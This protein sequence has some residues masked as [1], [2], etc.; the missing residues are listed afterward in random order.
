MPSCAFRAGYGAWL[1]ERRSGPGDNGSNNRAGARYNGLQD[2]CRDI[3][4]EL[5]QLSRATN[6]QMRDI[7]VTAPHQT[8][9]IEPNNLIGFQPNGRRLSLFTFQRSCRQ[10]LARFRSLPTAL[11]RDHIPGLALGTPVPTRRAAARAFEA[12]GVSPFSQTSLLLQPQVLD[13]RVLRAESEAAYRSDLSFWCS[14][15]PRAAVST[16]AVSLQTAA[17]A[18]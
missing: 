18:K 10:S 4:E 16:R 3:C 17:L 13:C 2:R 5:A 12:W 8:T 14:R 6:F 1:C 15:D 7:V 11:H 9:H